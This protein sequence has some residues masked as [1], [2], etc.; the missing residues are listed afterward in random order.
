M[1]YGTDL[2][3]LFGVL[4]LQS[5]FLSQDELVASM[6]QWFADPQR[7]L[8][9]ILVG[10]GALGEGELTL[11]EM[12]VQNQVEKHG[13]AAGSMAALGYESVALNTLDS[14]GESETEKTISKLRMKL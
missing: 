8:G 6:R 12:A 1:S 14:A 13:T 9:E 7:S 3:L 10:R 11:L 4:A 2:N 5:G